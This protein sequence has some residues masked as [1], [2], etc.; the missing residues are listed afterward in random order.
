MAYYP[1]NSASQI[2][3]CG[4]YY[5]FFVCVVELAIVQ[6][7][8]MHTNLPFSMFF[9]FC[10][11]TSLPLCIF[12]GD[13]K[14]ESFSVVFFASF[15]SHGFCFTLIVGNLCVCV[16]KSGMFLR[17]WWLGS[18][19]ILILF[20]AFSFTGAHYRQPSFLCS[21]THFSILLPYTF[22]FSLSLD[23]YSVI[24]CIRVP[25]VFVYDL[26]SF[27]AAL[28]YPLALSFRLVFF[29]LIPLKCRA[30]WLVQKLLLFWL[31]LAAFILQ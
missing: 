14:Y 5:C 2:P 28:S 15:L 25:C 26:L 8:T 9:F 31:L 6:T 4:Y 18:H 10:H 24:V 21:N 19:N 16:L 20:I 1:S 12:P 3:L 23:Y 22:S 27:A 11:L 17:V 29:T 13:A 7:S 30:F